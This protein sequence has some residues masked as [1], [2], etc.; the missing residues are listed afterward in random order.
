M[1]TEVKDRYYRVFTYQK[2]DRA[3]DIEEL[4]SPRLKALIA[5]PRTTAQHRVE[6]SVELAVR[7]AAALSPFVFF[8]VAAPLGLG[9]GRRGRGVAFSLSLVILFGFYGLLAV[10]MS[11]G[12]R[13]AAL[14]GAAPWLGDAVGLALGAIMTRR[15]LTR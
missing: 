12:R 13:H 6:Y 10:G 2:V 3:P 8:W 15:V 1:R 14:A 9:M 7:S 4:A 5:D 11:L